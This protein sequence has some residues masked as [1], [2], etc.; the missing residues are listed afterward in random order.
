MD[1]KMTVKDAASFLGVTESWVNK[2]L[3]SLQLPTTRLNGRLFFEY[4]AAR[5]L[6]QFNF[7]PQVIAFQIVKGG[8][9]K[10]SL[11]FEFS[12]RANLYGAR[13]LCIDLDQQ[14]NLT[15][16]LH[17]DAE[18]SPVMIDILAED[19]SFEHA[20]LS[21]HEGLDLLPSR[22]ENSMLDDVIRLR[23]FPLNRVYADPLTKLRE[24]YDLIVI[25]CPPSLGQSVSAI[26]LAADRIVAPV[27]P[28][29]F[30][31]AGL[32]AT[33]QAITDLS[34]RFSTPIQLDIL[35]NKFDPKSAIAKSALE[36]IQLSPLYRPHLLP[37]TIRL[38]PELPQAIAQGHSIFDDVKVNKA[39]QDI[40]WLTRYLLRLDE[41]KVATEQAKSVLSSLEALFA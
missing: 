15:H 11:A 37:F 20:I 38:S 1:P 16:A 32:K 9:G 36:S 3:K 10:T 22:I 4:P 30:A 35:F 7:K 13:V 25:D 2:Q 39:K 23:K 14:G 26:T 12:I 40:D 34:K 28:E 24:K 6:F 27:V 21:V 33:K 18:N 41:N 29:K 8:T 17:A 31:L 19:Y 5:E